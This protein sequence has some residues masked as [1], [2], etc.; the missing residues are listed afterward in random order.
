MRKILLIIILLTHSPY[1]YSQ[2]TYTLVIDTLELP[3]SNNP[4][5]ILEQRM[6]NVFGHPLLSELN[7]HG[8]VVY[9]IDEYNTLIDSI[10]FNVNKNKPPN[11]IVSN[12]QKDIFWLKLD[13]KWGYCEFIVNDKNID[14]IH[15]NKW[16]VYKNGYDDLRIGYRGEV[17]QV[18]GEIGDNDLIMHPF[19]EEVHYKGGKFLPYLALIINGLSYIKNVEL[20]TDT[21][22]RTHYHGYRPLKKYNRYLRA[23]EKKR[24]LT[25]KYVFYY[26]TGIYKTIQYRFHANIEIR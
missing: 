15:I 14:T 2:R 17:K 23:S 4:H 1:I 24:V 25:K 22:Q 13:N 5:E 3:K 10:S 18:N 8:I 19:S 20:K 11:L 6:E 12:I 21:I 26:F 16:I 9:Q 7:K